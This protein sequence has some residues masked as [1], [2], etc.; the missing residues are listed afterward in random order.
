MIYFCN[1]VSETQ[2]VNTAVISPADSSMWIATSARG[3]VRVGRNGK[4]FTYSAEKGDFSCNNIVALAFDSDGILWMKDAEGG[5]FSYTSFLGFVKQSELS[6]SV[7]AGL[8]ESVTKEEVAA[9]EPAQG[10]PQRPWYGLWWVLALAV[11]FF[12]LFIWQLL[13]NRCDVSKSPAAP[14]PQPIA[15]KPVTPRPAKP[16]P[17]AENPVEISPLPAETAAPAEKPANT[18]PRV[19][20]GEFAGKVL[21]IIKANFTNPEFGVEDV[22]AVLGMSRVHLNRKLKAENSP[23]P[24]DMIKSMRMDLA[25]GMLKEGSASISE[26]ASKCGFSSASYFSSAFKEY[27]GVAPAAYGK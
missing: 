16:L 22:A 3:L 20:D 18:S 8:E 27:F 9:D 6:Q 24:S 21:E 10:A 7:V 23:S 19:S 26:I 12:A 14:A 4:S 25:A 15:D 13:K 17:P 5:V 1:M 2:L 11:L